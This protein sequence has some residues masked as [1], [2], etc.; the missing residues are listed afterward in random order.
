MFRQVYNAWEI[1]KAIDAYDRLGSFRKASLLTGISKSTIHRWYSSFSFIHRP[2]SRP[3]KK[4]CPRRNSKYAGILSSL[5]T[6]FQQAGPVMRFFSLH[7]IQSAIH[8]HFGT[9][10][11]PS[12]SWIHKTLK[13]AR[14]SRRRIRDGGVC[15][16]P[17]H[18]LA[19][20]TRNFAKQLSCLTDQEIVCLDET[21]FCNVGN[22][23]QG[24][25]LKGKS[26]RKLWFQEGISFP[27]SW[28]L[29]L[30]K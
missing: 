16:R 30:I 7:A 27:W 6:M 17:S 26:R 19:A 5:Q 29:M 8:N 22:A 9:T 20:M 10:M 25:F 18:D 23:V 1:R 13:L 4:Q 21:G 2:S 24:Y 3:R 14:I 15:S 11:K 28:P 12:I